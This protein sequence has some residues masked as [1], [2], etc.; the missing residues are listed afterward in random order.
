MKLSMV[1]A[2]GF[3]VVVTTIAVGNT[4]GYA[5][6]HK[7]KARLVVAKA[8]QYAAE[9]QVRLRYYGGPKSPMSQ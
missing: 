6:V 2:I 9:H 3:T 7:A 4:A 8:P 1:L 5:H